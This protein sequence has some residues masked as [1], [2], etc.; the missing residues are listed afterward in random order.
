MHD[1][2][3]PVQFEKLPWRYKRG[4]GVGAGVL[5]G[6]LPNVLHAQWNLLAVA[7]GGAV[8]LWSCFGAG[9]EFVNERRAKEIGYNDWVS[10]SAAVFIVAII[11]LAARQTEPAQQPAQQ[12]EPQSK[13]A[14]GNVPRSLT[15]IPL[16]QLTDTELVE[17]SAELARQLRTF[18]AREMQIVTNTIESRRRFSQNA[19]EEEKTKI[20]N[21]NN[22]AIEKVYTDFK[23]EFRNR[24]RPDVIRI[25]NELLFRIKMRGKEAP[26]TPP[27]VLNVLEL[28]T[29]AG[30]NPI[31]D[32]ADHLESLGDLLR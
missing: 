27:S 6:F 24:Y 26:A 7:F 30:P 13:D 2:W 18:D 11:G 1:H 14:S 21:E 10:L 31:T 17:K 3:L 4:L 28:N 32:L 19:T 22:K 8:F 23:I 12:T 15:N 9:L 5:I 29:L 20:W 25:R 16:S